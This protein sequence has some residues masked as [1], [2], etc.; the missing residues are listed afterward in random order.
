MAKHYG[1]PYLGSKEKILGLLRDVFE[2]EYKKTYMIDL[3]CGGF[4]VSQY[5]LE[6]THF[7]VLANDLNDY[8]IE[9]YKDILFNN[10]SNI[11]KVWYDWV[12]KDTFIDV[13]DNPHKYPK[14]YVGYVIT[15]WSF[16]NSQNSY[17]FGGTKE[18][19]KHA[20]HQALVFNDWGL[21]NK[22]KGF[23]GFN[24]PDEILNYDYKSYSYKRILF[25]AYV[26]Q[27][28]KEVNDMSSRLENLER[29]ERL[30]QLENLER[31]QQL[32]RLQKGTLKAGIHTLDHKDWYEFYQ[33]I[34]KNILDQSFI[35]CDPPYEGTATYQKGGNFDYQKFWQWFRDCP[36]S[37][38]V[39]SYEAPDDIKPL[40]Y[41]LKMVSLSYQDVTR[42]YVKEH[43]YWNGKG[44]STPLISDLLFQ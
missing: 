25:M 41:E 38:Y 30:Q 9:L 42:K 15:I 8:V 29:L 13:R 33:S 26:K 1:I 36:Y 7:K 20:L 3:F 31:L 21:L 27:Y 2:R 43:I 17:L 39:S 23:E 10:S 5:A 12:S 11:S 22:R 40:D 16:G 28:V 19:E 4:S 37:V 24:I 34:P 35:Y 18:D 44:T 14:W 6:K 32:S